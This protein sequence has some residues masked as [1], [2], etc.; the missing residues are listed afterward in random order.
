MTLEKR[1][2][3][4]YQKLEK[5]ELAHQDMLEDI[6]VK[7]SAIARSIDHGIFPFMIA[8]GFKYKSLNEVKA[9]LG[10]RWYLNPTQFRN[11]RYLVRIYL[12]ERMLRNTG[13]QTSKKTVKTLLNLLFGNNSD[14]Q[15]K[16]NSKMQEIWQN[17]NKF[18]TYEIL[19]YLRD[20]LT[21]YERKRQGSVST[22]VPL[23][24]EMIDQITIQDTDSV[25]DPAC[26]N[27][28]F[29][30][31]SHEKNQNAKYYGVDISPQ[32]CYIAKYL[33]PWAEIWCADFLKKVF[34]MKKFDVIVGNPPF[35]KDTAK[36]SKIYP[37]FILNSLELLK[38]N[39]FLGFIT[40]SAWLKR[41]ALVLK[42]VRNMMKTIDILYINM[43]FSSQFQVGENICGFL[44]R[45]SKVIVTTKVINDGNIYNI[46]LSQNIDLIISNEDKLWRSIDDKFVKNN[47]PKIKWREDVHDH[48]NRLI[49]EGIISKHR[50]SE[51][52]YPIYYTASQKQWANK[53]FGDKDSLKVTVNLSGYWFSYKNPSKYIRITRA[54]SGQ[55]IMHINVASKQEGKN[56]KSF[57]S[58]KLYQFWIL[59]TKTSGFNSGLSKLPDLGRNKIWTDK[60]I[61]DHFGLTKEEIAYIE[62]TIK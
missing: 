48:Q 31:V 26:G 53:L 14:F 45:N 38:N 57:L 4:W 55:N 5:G 34:G 59:K 50:N 52:R 6:S 9:D 25:L 41:D 32:R 15:N 58:S 12:F 49:E 27:G 13:Y 36:N 19:D 24:R 44:V 51:Y 61:Y 28:T 43:D 8:T 17:K 1:I 33:A 18:G 40:P 60:E 22:P 35:Q 20:S 21:V 7:L 23:V 47:S 37:K 10:N 16:I 56:V 39:G 62:E 3:K 30:V 11:T 54:M 2:D 42:A 29:L 46:D